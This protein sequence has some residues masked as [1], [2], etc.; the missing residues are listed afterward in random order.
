MRLKR[1]EEWGIIKKQVRGGREARAH[2]QQLPGSHAAV[3][4]APQ[5]MHAAASSHPFPS[6]FFPPIWE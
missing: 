5:R 1:Q 2:L 3:H 6:V 4:A